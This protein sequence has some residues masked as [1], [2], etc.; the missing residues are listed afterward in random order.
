MVSDIH[1]IRDRAWAYFGFEPGPSGKGAYRD[2]DGRPPSLVG[3][4]EEEKGGGGGG[5]KGKGGKVGVGKGGG[6]KKGGGGGGGGGKRKGSGGQNRVW[7]RG[8]ALRMEG[9]SKSLMDVPG[10]AAADDLANS[11]L[12]A[13]VAAGQGHEAAAIAR[14][15][16][17]CAAFTMQALE[18]FW[19]GG[20]MRVAYL[21]PTEYERLAPLMLTPLPPPPG[22]GCVRG[23]GGR[24]LC[25]G[26]CG[27][28]IGSDAIY[29]SSSLTHTHTPIQ[30]RAYTYVQPGAPP[31][32]RL[33]PRRDAPPHPRP[34]P[35]RRRRA[36]ARHPPHCARGPAPAR[37]R[38]VQLHA[39]Q[40]RNR[41]LARVGR[42][43]PEVRLPA[44]P[45]RRRPAALHP[46]GGRAALD[47]PPHGGRPLGPYRPGLFAAAA[48]A[49]PDDALAP[50]AAHGPAHARAPGK[51]LRGAQGAG[52]DP[53][54]PAGAEARQAVVILV[55]GG[56]GGRAGRGGWGWGQAGRVVGSGGT[57]VDGV[58]GVG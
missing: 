42:R 55:G 2:P 8:A 7:T 39:D 32:R 33:H 14:G 45:A 31:L 30:H 25:D 47:G 19:Q 53:H 51:G 52:P 17:D 11:R 3:S 16:I 50:R 44:R 23:C 41:P 56:G 24:C 35:R 46:G 28:D 36:V 40:P 6:G 37:D 12:L 57:Y 15:G 10:V 9:R 27:V 38:V 21:A 20:G 18:A 29:R 22:S 43:G 26:D 13:R 5:G 34:R 48:P 54:P 49:R 1:G 4:L 58:W